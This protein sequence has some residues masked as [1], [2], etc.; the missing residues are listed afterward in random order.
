MRLPSDEHTSSGLLRDV[1]DW[2]NH[3]AWV[4]FRDHYDPLIRHWCGGFGLDKDS[5]DEV[6]QRIWIEL[7]ERIKTFRYDPNRTFRGWL[8]SVCKSRVVDFLRQRQALSLLSLDE[9]DSRPEAEAHGLGS[10]ANDEDG[11][12]SDQH[13]RLLLDEAKRI[14]AAVKGRV[15]PASW[16]AFWMVAVHDQR[17]ENVAK[18]LGVTRIAVYAATARVSRMLCDEGKSV[19]NRGSDGS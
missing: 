10:G 14:R 9:N 17:V 7:A 2:A 13:R 18:E 11:E 8:K 3:P 15:S 12:A 16:E 4:R 6:S 1:A 5:L 19:R